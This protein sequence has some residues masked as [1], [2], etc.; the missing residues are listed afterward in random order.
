M[1]H[2]LA[3]LIGQS[4]A[5]VCTG[6]MNGTSGISTLSVRCSFVP[7]TLLFLKSNRFG[8]MVHCSYGN[9]LFFNRS[10]HCV[11]CY[12]E[13][14]RCY[15]SVNLMIFVHVLIPRKITMDE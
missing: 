7:L 8:N 9:Y 4:S 5:T 3:G 2:R 13:L 1:R 11:P 6:I 10:S 12:Y 14:N 15:I